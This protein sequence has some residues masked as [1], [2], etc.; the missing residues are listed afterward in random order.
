MTVANQTKRRQ[1]LAG[2]GSVHDAGVSGFVLLP[3]SS[4]PVEQVQRLAPIRAKV[5]GWR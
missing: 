3:I 1:S 5:L 4:N 2:C